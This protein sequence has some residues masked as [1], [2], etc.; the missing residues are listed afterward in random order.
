MYSNVLDFLKKIPERQDFK[1]FRLNRDP[2]LLMPFRTLLMVQN[3]HGRVSLCLISQHQSSCRKFF[4]LYFQLVSVTED[5]HL[6]LY[7]DIFL[8][9]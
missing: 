9:K 5:W 4:V 6:S 7:I 8:S 1:V 2:L 3:E